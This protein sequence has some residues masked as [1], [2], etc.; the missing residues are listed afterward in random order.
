MQGTPQTQDQGDSL[1]QM[2]QE[3]LDELVK[4]HKRFME[5]R[6]GGRRAILR[7][8]NMSGLSLRE[9]DLRQAD[10]SGC[11]MRDM[12]LAGA[13]F[14]EAS[15]YACDLSNSN[16]NKTVFV[17]ADLRG[18][19]IESADLSG[20]DLDRADLR[21]GGF[22]TDGE[23]TRGN[24]VNFRGANLAGAK[25]SGTLASS[26]DFSDAIMSKTD[27]TGADLRNARFEGADLTEAEVKGAQLMGANMRSTILT[28]VQLDDI[29]GSGVDLTDSITDD[30][31]GKSL[32]EL[33]EP[34]AKLIKEHR[35]WVASVG[36]EGAQL[37]LSGYDLRILLSLAGENIG[38]FER[39]LLHFCARAIR[40]THVAAFQIT[41][42]G[43]LLAVAFKVKRAQIG[44]TQ[45]GVAEPCILQARC[46]EVCT[47][48]ETA[49]EIGFIKIGAL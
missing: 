21:A 8:I 23:F 44:V 16:L 3:Q 38:P 7:K 20:A 4:L 25:L 17:R 11:D 12:D 37:D 9:Q 41:R 40:V 18:S 34:L 13:N 22:S 15:L 29:R 39:R 10:F 30:N 28:G 36:K 27:L 46:T 49:A 42:A 32:D 48:Q 26:A 1:K 24:D 35:S 2:T 43:L 33:E 19:R 31:V 14:R 45:I 47:T 5:G 6:V